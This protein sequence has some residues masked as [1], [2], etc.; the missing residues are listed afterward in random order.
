MNEFDAAV[1][2]SVWN[3]VKDI[4]DKLTCEACKVSGFEINQDTVYTN[5]FFC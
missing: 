2:K 5:I 3:K 1:M 4:L